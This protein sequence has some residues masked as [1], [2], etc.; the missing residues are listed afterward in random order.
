M[1]KGSTNATGYYFI[2]VPA[3][4]YCVDVHPNPGGTWNPRSPAVTVHV[5]AGGNAGANFWFWTL[6]SYVALTAA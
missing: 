1:V 6:I 3:G 5:P 4:T 2:N